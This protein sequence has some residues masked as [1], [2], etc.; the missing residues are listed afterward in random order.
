MPKPVKTPKTLAEF[1][2]GQGMEDMQRIEDLINALMNLK[3]EVV[4]RG[5][6]RLGSASIQISGGAALIQINL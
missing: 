3:V 2:S 5:E 4:I 1:A 6:A